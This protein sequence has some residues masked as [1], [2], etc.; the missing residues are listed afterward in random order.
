MRQS[1]RFFEDYRNAIA[2]LG[3]AVVD[4][5]PI[6]APSIS[7]KLSALHPRFEAA[8]ADIIRNDLMPQ[9]EHLA[10]TA[11]A[12]GVGFTVDAEEADRLEQTLAVFEHLARS[13]RLRG[14]EG[15]GLAVQAYGKR[16]RAVIDWLDDLGAQTRARF[17]IRL[18]KGAYWD[19]EIKH[20]QIQG[21]PSYPVFTQKAATDVSYLACARQ[22]LAS[23]RIAPQFATH[24]VHT[25]TAIRLMAKGR[26]F[27][28]QRLHGMGEQL[29][30]V[31]HESG[32]NTP[33]RV[34]APV[35][36][37]RELLPYLIRRM[38]ENT[39][40]SSFVHAAFDKRYSVEEVVQDPI[41]ALKSNPASAIPLPSDIYEGRKNSSGLDLADRR[42][43]KGLSDAARTA[44][45]ALSPV[46]QASP[47]EVTRAI[48]VAASAFETWNNVSVEVRARIMERAADI[49]E[50]RIQEFTGL[51]TAEAGR[52]LRDSVFEVR[53]AVDFC[54][55]YALEARRVLTG[56]SLPSVTGER[57]VLRLGGRGVFACISPWNFPLAIFLGQVTAALVA[58]NTVI[59]KPAEQSPRVAAAAVRVLLEAGVPADVLHLLQGD[60]AIGK[61][62]PM[63]ARIAGVVFTGSTA[64]AQ[65]INKTLANREGPIATLIAETGGVNA[66]LVDASALLEQ[67]T[68]DVVMSGF[69]SA[70]QRCSSLR[71]LFIQSEVSDAAIEMIAGAM[72]TLRVGDPADPAT[73]VGPLIDQEAAEAVT[74]HIQD[75]QAAGGRIV[76]QSPVPDSCVNRSFVPPTLIELSDPAMLSR[77]VFGPVVH[78]TRWRHSELDRVIDYLRQSDY[79]LTFGVHSRI[80]G[81]AK[82][83]VSRARCGNSYINRNMVGAVVGS[84]PFGGRGLSG[85]GPKAGG[86]HYLA[87]FAAEEVVTENM[88]A[89]GGNV[90]LLQRV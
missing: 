59:A 15:L 77:E 41:A 8:Q 38:L 86:P 3:Q 63:D 29:Y 35:G 51:I 42:V 66:M 76:T 9:V 40:N 10:I 24:N 5:E 31:L 32:M 27:E 18:V 84:Q 61:I 19:T 89:I 1:Q 79:G 69:L 74:R 68:D 90:E 52:T 7:V 36:R 70:G 44:R 45:S 16:A 39:A 34:Y 23:E 53:E 65:S 4:G 47:R 67:V 22:M 54:R 62:I 30:A 43:L 78:V 71:H 87:R 2:V 13:P 17:C 50:S 60:A 58:G 55:Y 81:F 72:E 20:A 33:V 26:P 64:V 49:I 37:F 28:F 85:T 11:M 88:T 14:W 73:D 56:T 12:G 80:A 48:D 57:N 46:Q 83:V 75:I 21:L 25:V 6:D 82:R